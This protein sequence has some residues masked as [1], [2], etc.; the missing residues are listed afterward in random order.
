MGPAPRARPRTRPTRPRMRP[1]SGC[2]GIPPQ[3]GKLGNPYG[4]PHAAAKPAM[5]AAPQTCKRLAGRV[6]DGQRLP[7]FGDD[8]GGH[9][10]EL[11]DRVAPLRHRFQ[12][13]H[14]PVVDAAVSWFVR[15]QTPR[16]SSPPERSTHPPTPAVRCGRPGRTEA[17]RYRRCPRPSWCRAQPARSPVVRG[18]VRGEPADP[19]GLV[20]PR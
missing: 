18:G 20:Q 5:T 8:F 10:H 19:A 17:C 4:S 6:R 13:A 3:D 12:E 7:G 2:T 9:E 11:A 14:L 16:S 15:T 1:P